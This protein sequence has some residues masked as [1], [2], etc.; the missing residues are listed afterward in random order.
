MTTVADRKRLVTW[1]EPA[2]FHYNPIGAVH[3]GFAYVVKGSERC[4]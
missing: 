2:E 4:P 1:K 3:G